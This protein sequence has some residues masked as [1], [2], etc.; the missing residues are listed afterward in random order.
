MNE[1]GSGETKL[2]NNHPAHD[3]AHDWGPATAT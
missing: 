3:K 1:D 2:T